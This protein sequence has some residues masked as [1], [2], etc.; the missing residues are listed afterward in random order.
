LS[1]ASLT[2]LVIL[3]ANIKNNIATSIAHIYIRNKPITKTLYHALNIM[4][5]EAE[6]VTIR[7]G[8]NQA[9]SID[10]ISKI[11]IVID[12]I[13]A[14]KKIFDLS[15]HSFQKHV[16]AILRELH[17][18]FSYH[19]DNHI[20]FWDCPSHSNWHLYKAVDSKTKSIRLTPLYP[21]KLS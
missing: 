1:D 13:H 6:L 8:I 20:E 4:S 11:I 5:I 18:F 7:C 16:V 9:T 19:P 2:A 10:Y 15:F 14:A 12:S 21:N 17:Y 3:D